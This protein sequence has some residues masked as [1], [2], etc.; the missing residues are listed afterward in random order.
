[1][2]D[3]LGYMLEDEKYGVEGLKLPHQSYL[4]SIML[5]DD[6]TLYLLGY[7]VNLDRAFKVLDIYSSALGANSMDTKV[8]I[9]GLLPFLR[10]LFGKLI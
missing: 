10:I 5:A 1:M 7:L 9:F 3:I 8:D 2:A 4:T 6:T